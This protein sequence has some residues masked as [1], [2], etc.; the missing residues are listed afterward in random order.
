MIE[1]IPILPE[2]ITE[3]NWVHSPA[4][5][6][7]TEAMDKLYKEKG[8]IPPWIGYFIEVGDELAGSCGFT[9]PPEQNKVELAYW[10]FQEFEGRGIATE[11]CKKL[12]EKSISANPNVIIT[13]KTAP[14]INASVAILK[15]NGFQYEGVVQDHEIGDA[16]LWVC[17]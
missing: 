9:S 15:K 4:F 5:E 16:W 11:A 3:K 13:A 6:E 12:V 14:E 2:P 8:C 10:V 17:K 1:L 7:L